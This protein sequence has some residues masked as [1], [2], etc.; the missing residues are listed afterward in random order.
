MAKF[1]VLLITV[2][3]LLF[4]SVAQA[5]NRSVIETK[6]GKIRNMDVMFLPACQG[7]NFREICA[8]NVI[9]QTK[10]IAEW[11]GIRNVASFIARNKLDPRVTNSNTIILKG[12]VLSI[13]K[14]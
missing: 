1:I 13:K 14:V 3:F 4:T 11:V 8:P 2:S 12:I 5:S 9:E 10:T 7:V 6:P